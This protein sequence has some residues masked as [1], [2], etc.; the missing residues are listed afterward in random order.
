MLFVDALRHRL[1]FNPNSYTQ[2]FAVPVDIVKLN[3][4]DY[5]QIIARPMDFGYRSDLSKQV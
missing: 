4:P 2:V 5:Y 3:L 1:G